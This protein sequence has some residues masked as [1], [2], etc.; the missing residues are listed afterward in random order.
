MHGPLL[1]KA[2]P[3]CPEPAEPLLGEEGAPA[4]Y[5]GAAVGG[6]G[7]LALAVLPVDA[8]DDPTSPNVSVKPGPCTELSDV[9][10]TSTL[11]D[12]TTIG[13]G[14]AEPLSDATSKP[15]VLVPEYTF[16]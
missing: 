9:S 8:D 14:S 1:L 16:R 6:V 2:A 11:P 12:G 4:A 3:A 7:P 10:R 13:A 15:D 5:A